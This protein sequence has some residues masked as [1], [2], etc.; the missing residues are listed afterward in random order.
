MDN[1]KRIYEKTG[2]EAVL[3]EQPDLR[4]YLTGLETSFGYVLTD[5]SGTVFYT[6]SRYLEGAKAALAD[7]DIQ[8]KLYEGPLERI[9]KGYEEVAVPIA[10]T[11]HPDYEKLAGMGLKIADSGKAFEEIMSVKHCYEIEN[12]RLACNAA[13]NAFVSLLPRIKEGMSENDVA[14][15]LEYLMRK[16]GASG[17]SF[18]TI[19]AFGKNSSVPHH[20]TCNDKLKFGDIVLIDFGCK[21]NGYCSDCTRTFLFGDDN[22]HDEFKEAYSHVLKAHILVKER[23]SAGDSGKTADGYAREY[24]KESGLDKYFTHALG[25]GVGINV[26]EKPVLSPRSEDILLDNM[27]FSDEPGVYFE[28]KFGIRIEDTVMLSGGKVASLTDSDKKLIT[29]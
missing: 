9:L 17:T 16:N 12:I 1:A 22:R 2:A 21:V 14:A 8:V 13:D 18:S 26:H 28:G 5:K 24:L 10:R 7:K 27:V 23:L 4:Q 25:H 6:D 3:T 20:E 29:L 15:E 19:V 11:Y